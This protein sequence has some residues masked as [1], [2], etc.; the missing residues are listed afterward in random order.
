MSHID[1]QSVKQMVELRDIAEAQK[2]LATAIGDMAY[3]SQGLTEQQ[4]LAWAT[5]L[6]CMGKRAATLAHNLLDECIDP[7]GADLEGGHDAD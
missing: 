1:D 4:A 7:A 3:L 5:A 6:S 2:E